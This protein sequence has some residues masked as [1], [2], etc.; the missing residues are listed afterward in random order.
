MGLAGKIQVFM[1]AVLM[2]CTVAHAQTSV[3]GGKS[4]E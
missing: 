4:V 3:E 1:A 2:A